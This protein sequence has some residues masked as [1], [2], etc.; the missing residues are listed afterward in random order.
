ML[1]EERNAGS[2]KPKNAFG[3]V[4]Y[5]EQKVHDVAVLYYIFFSLY[6][7]LACLP[8]CFFRTEC[9]VIV[10][11]DYFCTDKAPLEVSMDNSSCLRCFRSFGKGPC[12]RFVRPRGEIGLQVEQSVG[13]FDKP[14]DPRFFQSYVARNASRSSK[15]SS[16]AMSASV[17]AAT[18]NSSAF[19][20]RMASRT[21]ST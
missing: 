3:C 1:P 17:A 12:P 15:L 5:V 4:L 16:S 10:V 8:A 7:Y 20:S 2:R 6:R 11:L 19:S 14:A 13:R 18:I 21:A 9:D